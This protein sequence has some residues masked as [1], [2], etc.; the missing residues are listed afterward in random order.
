MSIPKKKLKKKLLKKFGFFEEPKS[1]H[2]A[3]SLIVDGKTVATTYF[4]RS[5]VDIDDTLLGKNANQ[6]AVRLGYLKE[7]YSCTKSKDDYLSLLQNEGHL[8]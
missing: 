7:M 8:S 6:L 4:S 5:H 3:V 1:K 2:E